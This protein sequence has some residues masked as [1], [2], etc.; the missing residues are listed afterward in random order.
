MNRKVAFYS[1][2]AQIMHW[3]SALLII[4]LWPLGMVM[5]RMEEGSGQKQLYK[6]HIA[7]GLLVL[8]IA[9]LRIVWRVV[10]QSPNAPTGLSSVQVRTYKIAHI[11]QYI[12]LLSLTLSGLGMILVAGFGLFVG[13]FPFEALEGIP[14]QSIHRISSRIFIVLLVMHLGGV[15]RHQLTNGNV[16]T[17]MGIR[18]SDQ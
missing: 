6:V 11:F 9:L 2:G 18:L 12:I 17:R 8:L 10:N 16:M 1:K 7:I 13:D 15:I 3:L 14:P 5:T 4:I